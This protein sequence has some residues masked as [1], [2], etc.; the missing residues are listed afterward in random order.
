M[1]TLLTSLALAG[2][3]AAPVAQ[4]EIWDIDPGHTEVVASWNH[5][6]FSDQSLK[7]HEA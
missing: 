1:K 6:G 2:L 3:V 5:V 4:A 7:F